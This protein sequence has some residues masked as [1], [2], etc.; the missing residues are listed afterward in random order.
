MSTELERHGTL[1][2]AQIRRLMQ[3]IDPTHVEM[4]QNMSYMAQH[5]VR[6]EMTR[7]FGYGNWDNN[8]LEMHQ[9]YETRLEKDNP[10]YPK[11]GKGNP[12]YVVC[13]R[14]LV[15]VRIRD[16]NGLPVAEFSEWHAEEN[17]PLPNRGEANS[18][19]ITS[20]QSYALRRAVI[21][22][23]DRLGLGLY[24]KG[25]TNALVRGTLQWT[26]RHP[27]P[28]VATADATPD[29]V[30]T[31]KSEPVVE[32]ENNQ[33]AAPTTAERV[34]VVKP[35]LEAHLAMDWDSIQRAA[36]EWK[37]I[38][39]PELTIDI[40]EEF[41]AYVRGNGE[42]IAEKRAEELIAGSFKSE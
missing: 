34:A 26:E 5:E 37:A 10:Q 41:L 21:S 31:E 19:A 6:A 8:T 4:K 15:Q 16:L 42:T 22:L 35:L 2:D 18:M 32:D 9:L 30:S 36:A 13:Y 29:N 12:Y 14:A 28:V 33:D 39:T 27:K 23:G 7:I 38:P 3:A 20:V 25:S 11:N 17:A 24:D 40:L 1:T